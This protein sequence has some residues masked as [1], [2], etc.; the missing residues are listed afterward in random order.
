MT[1]EKTLQVSRKETKRH[2]ENIKKMTSRVR[3]D[4]YIQTE[5]ADLYNIDRLQIKFTG[6]EINEHYELLPEKT[7]EEKEG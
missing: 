7:E 2:Y 1:F 5:I 6:T 3:I 4:N